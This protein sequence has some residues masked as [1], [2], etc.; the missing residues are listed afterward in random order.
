MRRVFRYTRHCGKLGLRAAGAAL[1]GDEY[2]VDTV[3]SPLYPLGMILTFGNW[4]VVLKWVLKCARPSGRRM[5]A[6]GRQ[7]MDNTQPQTRADKGRQLQTIRDK[8]ESYSPR[9]IGLQAD[10]NRQGVLLWLL[11]AKAQAWWASPDRPSVQFRSSWPEL[12][13]RQLHK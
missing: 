9:Q 12:E 2:R 5:S 10:I 1:P 4:I 8:A 11:M 13:G 7:Q 3:V 6:G